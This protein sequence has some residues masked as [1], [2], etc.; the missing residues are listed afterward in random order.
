[1]ISEN[2]KI[3]IKKLKKKTEAG[4]AIWSKTTSDTEFK[5]ELNK[6]AITIDCWLADDFFTYA[7]LSVFNDVG[8]IIQREIFNNNHESFNELF[9][10]YEIVKRSYYKIDETLMT[11]FEELDSPKIVG[12]DSNKG[13]PFN[14]GI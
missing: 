12:K 13:F 4:Q 8:E 5:L 9:E 10:I 14:T 1:M 6:G 7:D 11:I 3:L 2:I